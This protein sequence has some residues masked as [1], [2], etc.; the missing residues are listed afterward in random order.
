M[1]NILAHN[2]YQKPS[3]APVGCRMKHQRKEVTVQC[4]YTAG[5]FQRKRRNKFYFLPQTDLIKNVTS[6]MCGVYK[7]N[8]CVLTAGKEIHHSD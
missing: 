4:S 1:L 6:C 2:A 8:K 3:P 7:E 5:A